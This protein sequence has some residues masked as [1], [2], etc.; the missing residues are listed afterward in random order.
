MPSQPERRYFH[1]YASKADATVFR[2][3]DL[4][5]FG[6][7]GRLRDVSSKGMTLV[8]DRPLDVGEAIYGVVENPVQQAKV[9][10][11]AR[12]ERVQVLEDG[13]HRVA[14]SFPGRLTVREVHDL[15]YDQTEGWVGWK[16]H[17]KT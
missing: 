10:V 12:V 3:H 16:R 13:L 9:N 15:K 4:M 5:R 2:A 11:R 1:R 17:E 8:I 14:C 7:R 6:I